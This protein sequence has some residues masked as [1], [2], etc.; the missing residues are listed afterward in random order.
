MSSSNVKTHFL[1]LIS[2]HFLQCRIEISFT[3]FCTWKD[4]YT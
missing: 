2:H 3:I 1:W 4:K